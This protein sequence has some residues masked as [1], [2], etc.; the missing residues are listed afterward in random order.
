MT[1]ADP[2]VAAI[3]ARAE[4]ATEWAGYGRWD[5]TNAYVW[6]T[7]TVPDPTDPTGQTPMP[8]QAEV[9]RAATTE[10]AEFIA[11]ADPD[12]VLA[13]CDTIDTLRAQRAAAL[14]LCDDFMEDEAGA[15]VVYVWRLRAAL[16]ANGDTN[17]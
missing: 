11:A 3:R 8:E 14:A 6:F 13:L 15:H 5:A 4:A 12:T 9:A 7:D 2:D 17:G 16:T 1:A 10:F